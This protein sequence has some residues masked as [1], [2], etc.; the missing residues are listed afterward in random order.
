MD[1]SPKKDS[2]THRASSYGKT[3]ASHV[4]SSNISE[5]SCEDSQMGGQTGG[6]G[7]FQ[8]LFSKSGTTMK[9]KK[10]DNYYDMS[11]LRK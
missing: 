4:T 3:M 2:H 10:I 11:Y 8:N 5:N 1:E 7:G 6:T 9:L